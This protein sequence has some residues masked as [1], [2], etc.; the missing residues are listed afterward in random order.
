MPFFRPNPAARPS[1]RRRPSL[2]FS[3]VGLVYCCMMMFMGLAAINSGANL[4]Y[5][6]FG[7]MIGILLLSGVLS[8]RVLRKLAVHRVLP[9]HAVVGVPIPVVYQFRNDKR[10]WPSLSVTVSELD[11]VDGFT[12]QP[13]GY[14]LHAAAGMTAAVPT[15]VIPRRRGVHQLDRFQISTSFPFGFLKRAVADRQPDRLLVYPAIGRVDP[16]VL[17][18]CRAAEHTGSTLRPRPHGHDEFYGV[19]EHRPGDNPR[20]IYWKRSART[21][22]SGVLIAKEMTQVSPPRVLLLVDTWL[23]DDTPDEAARVERAVAMAASLADRAIEQDLSVGLLA[24]DG[25]WKRLEPSRGKR[26][27]ADLLSAL[28]RLPQNVTADTGRLLDQGLRHTR[29]GTTA[30]LFTPRAVPAGGD[31]R[32][33]GAVVVIPADDEQ[34]NRWFTFDPPVDFGGSGAG[35]GSRKQGGSTNDQVPMTN[36]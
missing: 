19:K 23:T 5:G 25:D 34:A 3:L 29:N 21:A 24:W 9:D 15:E 18:L 8:K 35:N 12:K 4:L 33:R 36:K 31:A 28:A 1:A 16:G 10:F 11:G 26:H 14:L 22:A 6:V 7:L 27:R 13:Q 17:A 30:V 32:T 20:N 2:D